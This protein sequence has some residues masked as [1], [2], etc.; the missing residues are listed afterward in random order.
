MKRKLLSLALILA[1]ALAMAP[2][3]SAAA[4]SYPVAGGNIYFD[5]TTGAITDCDA[6][7]TAA[8]IPAEIYGVAVTS[9]GNRAFADCGSLTSVTIPD[10]VTSIGANAFLN[11][12]S[13]TSVVIPDSVT[14]MR[15]SA[16]R[17][18]IRLSDVTLGRGVTEI[19]SFCFM[20]C[21]A[22]TGISLPDSVTGLGQGAFMASGLVSITLPDS[23]RELDQAV[24]ASC[25]NLTDADLGSAT[26]AGVWLFQDCPQLSQVTLS[27]AMASLPSMMFDLC[28]ALEELVIPEG[29]TTVDA[30]LFDRNCNLRTLTLPSTIQSIRGAAFYAC[31][32]LTDVYYNGTALDWAAVRVSSGNDPLITANVH[33]SEPV[34]GFADVSTG[35]YYGDAVAWAVGAGITT[36]TSADTFSPDAAV[37][38]AQAVTFLWRAA[39]SPEPTATSSPFT[40]AADPSAYYYKAVLWA[41]EQ[42][43]TN[44]VSATV[45]GTD[46]SVAYDQIL[47]FLARTAGADT[48]SGDW[49]Q[50]AIDWA[51]EN[52]LT[53]GLTFSAKDA[54]PRADVV[55]CLWFLG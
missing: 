33:F 29:V 5:A 54:C 20:N 37:T 4:L 30:N 48:G 2:A 16:F 12:T 25:P 38:R 46:R 27:P 35:D 44:G 32:G 6:T 11:C 52:G 1:L 39:G 55:Y 22:L 23:V 34:A 15:E 41:A 3:A 7:V 10:T 19:P 8:E 51:A 21:A 53:D 26:Y 17:S 50:A 18:C 28:P 36:G 49:S 13:L 24:F 45:F 42:G 43:I 31:T 9:I 47:A 14:A 40:D